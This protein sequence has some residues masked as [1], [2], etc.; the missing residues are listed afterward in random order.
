M[1]QT[2]HLKEKCCICK[3][4]LIS[5]YNANNPA[6]INDDEGAYCC[7]SCNN[8]FVI[9]LRIIRAQKEINKQFNKPK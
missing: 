1:K 5:V 6:P 8:Q 3:A 7:N 9:P 4:P 2:K